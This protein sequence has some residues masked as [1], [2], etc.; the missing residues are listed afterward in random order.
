[1]LADMQQKIFSLSGEEKL[2]YRAKYDSLL[3]VSCVSP[4][5]GSNRLVTCVFWVLHW[6]IAHLAIASIVGYSNSVV[7]S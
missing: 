1:M 3:N 7:K 2:A 4:G 5:S 6:A